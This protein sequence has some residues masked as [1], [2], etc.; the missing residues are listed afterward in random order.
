MELV[1]RL[2]CCVNCT[3]VNSFTVRYFKGTGTINKYI[4]PT[5]VVSL[6]SG[7]QMH[8][9]ADL[10]HQWIYQQYVKISLWS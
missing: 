5:I 4:G 2:F 10:S 3:T 6:E 7:Q 1:F 9:R 8:G